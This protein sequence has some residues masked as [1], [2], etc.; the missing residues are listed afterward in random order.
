MKDEIIFKIFDRDLQI[1]PDDS[2][3]WVSAKLSSLC[4]NGGG[5]FDFDMFYDDDICGTLR[6]LSKYTP[7]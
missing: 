2:I 5:E 3:G 1:L 6:V 4:I 7:H